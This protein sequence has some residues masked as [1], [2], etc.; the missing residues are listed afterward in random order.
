[1]KNFWE[2]FYFLLPGYHHLCSM[3]PVENDLHKRNFNNHVSEIRI[4]LPH[5]QLTEQSPIFIN[6]CLE[7]FVSSS[8]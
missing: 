8:N 4:L 1:M 5:I 6:N 7:Q 2:K 3:I